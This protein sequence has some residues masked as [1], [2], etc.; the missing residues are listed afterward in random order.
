[1]E[2]GKHSRSVSSVLF[3]EMEK[4]VRLGKSAYVHWWDQ[5]VPVYTGQYRVWHMFTVVTH[6]SIHLDLITSLS[7]G[8]GREIEAVTS[9][10][11]WPGFETWLQRPGV[12]SIISERGE[13][14]VK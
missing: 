14:H 4:M 13:R 5:R 8:C 7:G 1:M 10:S 6:F 3:L 2:A 9:L 12:S 11:I